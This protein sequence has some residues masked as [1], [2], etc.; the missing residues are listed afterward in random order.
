[1]L[2]GG[3][4]FDEDPFYKMFDEF[5]N[6]QIDHVKINADCT[7]LNDVSQWSYDVIVFYNFKNKLSAKGQENLLKLC[8]KGIGLVVVHHAIAGFPDWA[9]WPKIVGAEYFLADKEIDG[10]VWKRCTYKHDVA[11]DVKV[12]NTKS[13][14]TAGVRDFE[15]I[16]E[17]YKGYRLE[18]DNQILL[19]TDKPISQKEIGWTR[20]FGKSRVCYLQ[21]GHGKEAYENPN[22]R[23]LVKQAI[24][25]A[26]EF[27]HEATEGNERREKW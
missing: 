8:D 1:M 14:V 18:P 6:F 22:Y 15:I 2:T 10:S 13:A 17:T 12:E 26:G 5:D 23:Q 16:D 20:V 19:T 27:Y 9:I 25:W 21:L 7:Y 11:F 4:G 3:H 24:N